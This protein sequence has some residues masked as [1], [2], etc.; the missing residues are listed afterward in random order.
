ME[1]SEKE[2]YAS[3]YSDNFN[4]N[5]NNQKRS[6]REIKKTKKAMSQSSEEELEK[7]SMN[8]EM[9]ENQEMQQNI[10]YDTNSDIVMEGNLIYR[11]E[12]D[13]IELE[14]LW[15]I[16]NEE[17]RERFSY[18]L[19]KQKDKKLSCS[20]KMKI[21]SNLIEANTNIKKFYNS[22]RE[23]YVLNICSANLF[24]SLL[25]PHS[26][27]FHTILNY[28]SG[29]YHGF[30][31]YYNKTMEDRFYINFTIE[32]NQVRINGEGTNSLGNFN[33]IGFINFYTSKGKLSIFYF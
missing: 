23:E 22:N 5:E 24:E 27:V 28:L 20:V 13:Q 18:L 3:F 7:E 2:N 26:N 32:D 19:L 14:G 17:N 11:H 25:I 31:L 30:F 33:V 21:D 15:T 1:K 10:M 8:Y 6:R 16:N 4:I 12:L 9:N 29:E